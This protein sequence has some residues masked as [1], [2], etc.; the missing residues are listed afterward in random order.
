MTGSRQTSQRDWAK[1]IDLIPPGQRLA[2]LFLLVLETVLLTLAAFSE[3]TRLAAIILMFL[4]ALV[5]LILA[6]IRPVPPPSLPVPV[7]ARYGLAPSPKVIGA[8]MLKSLRSER[9]L[10]ETVE[11]P[12]WFDVVILFHRL[13]QG[14]MTCTHYLLTADRDF[15]FGSNVMF[16][17]RAG[18]ITPSWCHDL[19]EDDLRAGNESLTLRIAFSQGASYFVTERRYR[20]YY[21]FLEK[22][23]AE[24]RLGLTGRTLKELLVEPRTSSFRF[25]GYK[26]IEDHVDYY[27]DHE[28]VDTAIDRK[29]GYGIRVTTDYEKVYKR[30]QGRG[31]RSFLSEPTRRHITGM[32][33]VPVF[34]PDK[35]TGRISHFLGMYN[36]D[37]TGDVTIDADG[38]R[39]LVDLQGELNRLFNVYL[40]KLA[41]RRAS[42][43]A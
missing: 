9:H 18:D 36:I 41:S 11:Y 27:N 38:E 16:I 20:P 23:K 7:G 25:P 14:F 21:M 40:D 1:L 37:L 39:H 15:V 43:G 2:A 28:S 42:A 17:R 12:D 10:L 13:V 31:Y 24:A 35:R 8:E 19:L 22:D 30:K 26:D 6:F 29:I 3:K 5:C 4:I 33:N 34:A 32:V